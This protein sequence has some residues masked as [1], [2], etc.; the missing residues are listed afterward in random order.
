[1]NT[2]AIKIPYTVIGQGAI[3]G[4]GDM[5]KELGADSVL[6]I[7]DTGLVKAGSIEKITPTLEKVGCKYDVFDGCKPNCPITNIEECVKKISN[8]K[9]DLLIGVGG[10]S[11]L[12]LVKVASVVAANG[13]QV[14]DIIM[15]N[16]LTIK[17]SYPKIL[18]PTTAGTGSEWS[19]LANVTDEKDGLKKLMRYNQFWADGVIIDPDLTLNLPQ[20]IT[21]ET[22]FDA[23]TH[24]IESYTACTSTDL[25]DILAEAAIKMVADNILTVYAKGNKHIEA[26]YKMAVASAIAMKAGE[27]NGTGFAHFIDSFIVSQT[28]ISHGAALAIIL[29]YAMEFNLLSNPKKFARIAEL[30]GERVEGLTVMEA[31]GKSVEAVKKLIRLMG[32]K[33]RLSEVGFGKSDIPKLVD[34][35]FRL[36]AQRIDAVNP[37]NASREEVTKIMEAAL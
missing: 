18:I 32:M 12:D 23:L 35:L 28:H 1:M 24:A 16:K 22:G 37:R 30:L 27:I 8:G 13:W 6:I 2:I 3:C 25:G 10:G 5:V 34:D 15:P 33:Q 31:A 14:H 36:K 20:G 21:A 29:P 4:I 17:T 9:Y 11:V 19:N 7:T 26:R